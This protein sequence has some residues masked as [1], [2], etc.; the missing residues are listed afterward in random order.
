MITDKP[1]AVRGFIITHFG[2]FQNLADK[3]N[4]SVG[5]VSVWANGKPRGMLKYAPEICFTHEV[6]PRELVNAVQMNLEQIN[7]G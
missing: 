2:T 5:A 3:L 7:V 4:V 6:D 1:N